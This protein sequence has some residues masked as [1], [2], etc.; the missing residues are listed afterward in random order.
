MDTKVCI[1]NLFSEDTI[2]IPNWKLTDKNI[3][4]M[5]IDTL[6]SSIKAN[7][8]EMEFCYVLNRWN[9]YMDSLWMVSWVKLSIRTMKD[10][11]KMTIRCGLIVYG[12]SINDTDNVGLIWTSSYPISSISIVYC[13]MH[14]MLKLPTS[15]LIERKVRK[16]WIRYNSNSF[17]V[18]L[19]MSNVPM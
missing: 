9:G 17:N 14:S 11:Q 8:K 1:W 6:D 7:F 18:C 2:G 5:V 12:E 16:E 13:R 10:I 3:S 4:V 19:V 15:T